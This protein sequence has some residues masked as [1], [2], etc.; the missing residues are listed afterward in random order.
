M[1]KLLTAGLLLMAAGAALIILPV[2]VE[3]YMI[4]KWGAAVAAQVHQRTDVK[5]M[6]GTYTTL[7]WRYEVGGKEHFYLSRKGA[8]GEKR[9]VGYKGY[10]LVKKD[11][12]EKVYELMMG[13]ERTMWKFLSGITIAA[14][15][16]CLGIFMIL[17]AGMMP[18]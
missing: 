3:N 14:G 15:V 12:P 7:V 11:C 16:I 13:W 5:K 17:R 4:W 6:Y 1:E 18:L 9:N 2:R 8:Y 10:L